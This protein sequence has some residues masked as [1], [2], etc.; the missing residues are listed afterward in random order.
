MRGKFEGIFASKFIKMGNLPKRLRTTAFEGIHKERTPL[1]GG[2]QNG[3][4]LNPQSGPH[5]HQFKIFFEFL[6]P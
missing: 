5:S 3:P 6:S 4:S 1:G 2:S